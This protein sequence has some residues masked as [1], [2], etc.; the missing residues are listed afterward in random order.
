MRLLCSESSQKTFSALWTIDYGIESL[1]GKI[2][3][4]N[5]SEDRRRISG[6]LL[7]AAVWIDMEAN[8]I[9]AC[10]IGIF[11][12]VM[13]LDFNHHE[14]LYRHRFNYI[15]VSNLLFNSF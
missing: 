11:R 13:S 1:F 10:I 14:K 12:I 8:I 3:G 9:R 4:W 2:C 6:A 15:F 5:I 7:E